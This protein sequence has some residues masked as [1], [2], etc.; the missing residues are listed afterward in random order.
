MTFIPTVLNGVKVFPLLIFLTLDRLL[1]YVDSRLQQVLYAPFSKPRWQD[2]NFP[3]QDANGTNL[4]DPWSQTGR[5]STP[6]DQDFYLILSLAVGGTNSYFPDSMG[7]KP[8]VDASP[9]AMYDFWQAKDKWLPTWGD[10]V[11]RALQIKNV[12]MYQQCD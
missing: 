12:K 1:T 11:E 9:R 8:W 7:G 10:G 4:V 5:D 6:F 3:L 2:G